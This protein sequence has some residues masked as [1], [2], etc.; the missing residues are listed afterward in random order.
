MQ[1]LAPTDQTEHICNV[2]VTQSALTQLNINFWDFYISNHNG[3]NLASC[4]LTHMKIYWLNISSL[5]I[6]ETSTHFMNEDEFLCSE[7]RLFNRR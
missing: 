3:L 4:K 2:S 7:R 6:M 5:N 1:N